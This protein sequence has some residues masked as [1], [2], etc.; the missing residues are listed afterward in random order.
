MI[1]FKLDICM[2]EQEG[3]GLVIKGPVNIEG[4]NV[5]PNELIGFGDMLSDVIGHIIPYLESNPGNG[6]LDFLQWH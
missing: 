6:L 1:K 5:S 2:T 3:H 4:K